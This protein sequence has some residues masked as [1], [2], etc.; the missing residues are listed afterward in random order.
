VVCHRDLFRVIERPAPRS[1]WMASRGLREVWDGACLTRR[2]FRAL[3]LW[4]TMAGPDVLVR[5][6]RV[7]GVPTS[8]PDRRGGYDEGCQAYDQWDDYIS[9]VTALAN[10]LHTFNGK[11][12]A[13]AGAHRRRLVWLRN[14]GF[15]PTIERRKQA[16]IDE[17]KQAAL[18]ARLRRQR[19]QEAR[20]A[21]HRSRARRSLAQTTTSR[22]SGGNPPFP[23]RTG[24]RCSRGSCGS[25]GSRSSRVRCADTT[26]SL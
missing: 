1:V 5:A 26:F 7:R 2:A 8:E 23:P 20:A 16:R 3:R 17:R 15:D 12:L 25:S 9:F 21:I 19:H 4:S 14:A 6:P 11:L 13:I 10:K 24:P 18:D 22:G